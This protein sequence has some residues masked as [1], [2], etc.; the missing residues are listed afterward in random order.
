VPSTPRIRWLDEPEE[1]DYLAADSFLSMGGIRDNLVIGDGYHRASAA[2][3][4]DEV[5]GDGYHRA[6]AAHRVDEDAQVPGRLLWS[7]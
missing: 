2:H 7:N 4:V 6:S 5:I 1:K 3:R